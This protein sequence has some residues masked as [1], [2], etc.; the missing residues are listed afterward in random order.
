MCSSGQRAARWHMAAITIV[1]IS[2]LIISRKDDD[3][4]LKE[5][6]SKFTLNTHLCRPYL[7]PSAVVPQPFG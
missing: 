3:C 5:E 1:Q 2:H 6:S 7:Q 4:V